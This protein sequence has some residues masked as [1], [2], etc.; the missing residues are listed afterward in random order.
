MSQ[1]F[2]LFVPIFLIIW[3]Q[4]FWLFVSTFS[5]N[6]LPSD[7]SRQLDLGIYS[8]QFRS[9]SQSRPKFLGFR[10]FSYS[11]YRLSLIGKTID[12]SSK[13]LNP[14]VINQFFLQTFKIFITHTQKSL[15][16]YSSQLINFWM[17]TLE[18]DS[19]DFLI[20]SRFSCR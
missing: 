4:I 2:L 6:T 8:W 1:F 7:F 16:N 9:I 5:I 19:D 14:N 3:S 17:S 13:F 18:V 10:L 11:K 20:T 12:I 15:F